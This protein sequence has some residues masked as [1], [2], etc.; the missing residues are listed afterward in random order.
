MRGFKTTVIVSASC[1]M[2][3]DM[4]PE[5]VE[6]P[7]ASWAIACRMYEPLLNEDTVYSGS[8]CVVSHLNK[9]AGGLLNVQ[10]ILVTVALLTPNT[11][12]DQNKYS[13]HSDIVKRVKHD[14]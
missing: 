9:E 8:A 1:P 10:L 12:E 6:V 7:S 14:I 5:C 2:S 4:T 11:F 13:K 3:P